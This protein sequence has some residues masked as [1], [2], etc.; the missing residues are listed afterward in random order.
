MRNDPNLNQSLEDLLRRCVA[1]GICLPHCATW[2]ATG[3]EVHSPRG[4]LL[5]LEDLLQDPNPKNMTEY[6]QAFDFC[7]GCRACETVCPS[8][9]PF[10]LLEHGQH[11]VAPY[12]ARPSPALSF[13]NRRLDSSDRPA[14]SGIPPGRLEYNQLDATQIL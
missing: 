5:L 14:G 3:N 13:L 1:C 8:G 10:S 7:I 11:L 4:R 12:T 2:V 6:A 9:V